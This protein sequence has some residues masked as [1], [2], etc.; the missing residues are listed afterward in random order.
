M[1]ECLR[2]SVSLWDAQYKLVC[3]NASL[4]SSLVLGDE[5]V[6]FGHDFFFGGCE[7]ET[8]QFA[9]LELTTS[10][11]FETE[12]STLK[13]RITFLTPTVHHMCSP[14]DPCRSKM[15]RKTVFAISP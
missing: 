3:V 8:L 9:K 1:C 12:C 4:T 11:T 15:G 5:V 13:Y 6:T 7:F 10:T 14:M 2:V